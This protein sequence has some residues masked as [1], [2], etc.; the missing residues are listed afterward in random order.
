MKTRNRS[1]ILDLVYWLAIALYAWSAWYT[2]F[3]V[4]SQTSWLYLAF[5]RWM[6]LTYFH[7]LFN[8]SL[9][10]LMILCGLKSLHVLLSG[11]Q[12]GTHH[13]E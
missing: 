12:G 2:Q 7:D 11:I 8:F 13:E 10:L 3:Y 5:L 4:V 1:L 9:F 6:T